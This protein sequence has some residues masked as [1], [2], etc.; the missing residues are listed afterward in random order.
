[1]AGSVTRPIEALIGAM[2]KVAAGNFETVFPGLGRKD[3]IGRLADGFNHMVSQLGAARER[4]VADRARTA[5]MQAELTRVARLTTMGRL[6][7]SM[8]HEINQ[9]LGRSW[10]MAMRACAGLPVR[11]RISTKRE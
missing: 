11:R 3:E 5:T 7:A 8:A 6:A 1:M 2:Q 10:Q 4:E 9:P